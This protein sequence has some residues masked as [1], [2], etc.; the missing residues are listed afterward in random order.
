[1]KGTE[2]RVSVGQLLRIAASLW[3]GY[4]VIL[5][6]FDFSISPFNRPFA[7]WYYVVNGLTALAILGL[8]WWGRGQ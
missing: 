6:L 5:A 4:L 1:M 8:A 7:Y 2:T 3:L